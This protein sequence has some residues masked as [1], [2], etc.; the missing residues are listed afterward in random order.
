[1]QLYGMEHTIEKLVGRS[2]AE[3]ERDLILATIERVNGDKPDAARILGI[4]LRT[5]YN[6][7]EKYGMETRKIL[8]SRSA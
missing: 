8:V 4:T 5:V 2:L 1:M 7:L 3:V 6:R